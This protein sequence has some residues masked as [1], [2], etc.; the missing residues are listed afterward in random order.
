MAPSDIPV[1]AIS[2]YLEDIVRKLIQGGIPAER[3]VDAVKLTAVRVQ[4]LWPVSRPEPT[5]AAAPPSDAPT[6]AAVLERLQAQAKPDTPEQVE[7]RTERR[8]AGRPW[9]SPN[10]EAESS[11][12]HETTQRVM[13]DAPTYGTSR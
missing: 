1:E 9:W 13:P 2:D 5:K 12:A 8:K 4:P 6:F 3:V 11:E 10:S 7:D